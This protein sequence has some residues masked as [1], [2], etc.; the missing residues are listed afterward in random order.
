MKRKLGIIILA[1]LLCAVLAFTLVACGNK[2]GGNSGGSGDNTTGNSGSSS[3]GGLEG[4]TDQQIAAV[5]ADLQTYLNT[6]VSMHATEGSEDQKGVLKNDL[7]A[8]KNS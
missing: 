2:N 6:W 8:A 1:M 4:V 7:T 5:E 3:S